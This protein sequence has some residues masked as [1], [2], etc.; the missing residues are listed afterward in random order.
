MQKELMSFNIFPWIGQLLSIPS[1]H[2]TILFVASLFVSF[3]FLFFSPVY[4][5]QFKKKKKLDTSSY[6]HC[7]VSK[8]ACG[9]LCGV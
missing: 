7:S 5:Q 6:F 3:F 1:L 2:V 4:A 9:V 8:K